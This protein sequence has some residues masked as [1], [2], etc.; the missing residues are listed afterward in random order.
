M[1]DAYSWV[2]YAVL[3]LALALNICYVL[4]RRHY[5]I[6]TIMLTGHVVLG[7]RGLIAVT[8]FIFGSSR[9][10]PLSPQR[11]FVSLYWGV[12]GACN[13]QADS[14]SDG[15]LGFSIGHPAI[16]YVMDCL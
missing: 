2:P 3:L 14:G 12:P 11:C 10:R 1:G 16:V 8:L 6:M 5:R 4:L 7:R 13:V 9:G 15:R